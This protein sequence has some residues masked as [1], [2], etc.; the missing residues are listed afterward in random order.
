MYMKFTDTVNNSKILYELDNITLKLT[1]TIV[2]TG[3]DMTELY[4][5]CTIS[6]K[7]D[8]LIVVLTPE[9]YKLNILKLVYLRT[10]K[11]VYARFIRLSNGDCTIGNWCTIPKDTVYK[12]LNVDFCILGYIS[13]EVA[14]IGL[15]L[16]SLS[17]KYSK[18]KALGSQNPNKFDSYCFD[19]FESRLPSKCHSVYNI[20]PSLFSILSYGGFLDKLCCLVSVGEH[21]ISTYCVPYFV[22][23]TRTALFNCNQIKTI[24]FH[25]GFS[26]SEETLIYN[27]AN[28]EELYLPFDIHTIPNFSINGC[29][30]LSAVKPSNGFDEFINIRYLDNEIFIDCPIIKRQNIIDISPN[31]E[32]MEGSINE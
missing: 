30:R 28:L 22:T 9:M 25:T 15:A 31:I 18:L 6:Y 8:R 24:R 7:N 13:D 21:D 1:K 27:C 16:Q 3:I 10:M 32:R 11:V 2:N 17:A 20:N 23:Y 5:W 14:N 26:L 4:D 19:E 29:P 12:I